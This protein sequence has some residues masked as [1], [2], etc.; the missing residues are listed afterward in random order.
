MTRPIRKTAASARPRTT[1]PP[2]PRRSTTDRALARA[3]L[4]ARENLAADPA[5]DPVPELPHW[6][7]LGSM[8]VH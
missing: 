5:R 6:P 7:I 2:H 3:A 8:L 4:L 1:P